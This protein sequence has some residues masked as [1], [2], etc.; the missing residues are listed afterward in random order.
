MI[1]VLYD[2]LHR[3]NIN[4][5]HQNE[6]NREFFFMIKEKSVLVNQIL[7]SGS[8]RFIYICP[9]HYKSVHR[10]CKYQAGGI[11][12]IYFYSSLLLLAVRQ[13]TI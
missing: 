11:I 2:T 7:N 4:V 9:T 10:S 1:F 6:V 5:F 8:S 3:I 13:N 12:G